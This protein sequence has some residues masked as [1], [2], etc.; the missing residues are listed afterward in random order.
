MRKRVS[1][2]SVSILAAL[3]LFVC[4]API[5]AQDQKAAA[6]PKPSAGLAAEILQ[7]WNYTGKKLADMAAD[8]PEDKLDYKATPVQRTFAEQLLHAAGANYYFIA[9]ATGT[10]PPKDVEQPPRSTYKTRAQIVEYIKKVYAD[11][12]AVI[13]RQGDKGMLEAVKSPFG[14][15][16]STRAALFASAIAHANDHYGQC[17]VY[18]RLNGLVPPESRGQQQ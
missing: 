12:A 9:A 14:N 13:T 15:E 8:F 10:K 16:M 5:R 17:V 6:A 4:A 7:E 18:Y 3:F 11:G 2:L 1:V